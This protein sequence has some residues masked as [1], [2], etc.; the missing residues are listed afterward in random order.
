[1]TSLFKKYCTALLVAILGLGHT[2]AKTATTFPNENL[3]YE[4]VY[5]WGMIWK[6]AA[7]ATLSLSNS[8]NYYNTSLV[9]HTRSWADKIYQVRDTLTCTIQKDGF[10]PIKYVKTSHEGNHYGK[11]IVQYSY[12]ANAST[13]NCTVIRKDKDTRFITLQAPGQAYD[14]LSVFYFLRTID[15]DSF[16]KNGTIKSVI[17]SG[18]KKENL[19]VKYV[20]VEKIELRDNSTHIAHHI[21]FTFTQDGQTKSSDD[22]H[23][24]IS[25]DSRHIPLLLKGSLPIGEVRVYYAQ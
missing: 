6:H 20:N 17:F 14:M 9:A 12:A 15:F 19:T 1:M 8:G 5:H 13:A 7:S 23:C 18:R 24:W 22:I 11:D 16:I 21:T 10:K 25:T 3:K 2:S 4:I